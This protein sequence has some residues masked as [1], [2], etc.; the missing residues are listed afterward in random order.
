MLVKCPDQQY[1]AATGT[2]FG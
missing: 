2:S 1:W